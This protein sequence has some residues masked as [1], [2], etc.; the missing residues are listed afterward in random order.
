LVE[1]FAFGRAFAEVADLDPAA[2]DQGADGVVGF[3]E[4]HTHFF[5]ELTLVQ[6]GVLFQV[7]EEAQS[8][9]DVQRGSEG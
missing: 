2:F 6:G 7:A 9:L 4:A 1:V 5:R 3:A 8:C